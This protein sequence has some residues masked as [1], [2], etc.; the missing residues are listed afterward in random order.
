MAVSSFQ[1]RRGLGHS[2][3]VIFGA[4]FFSEKIYTI[5]N[6][7]LTGALLTLKFGQVYPIIFITTRNARW[8]TGQQRS[9]P[10]PVSVTGQPLDGAPA[11]CVVQVLHFCFHSS[12][13]ESLP[14][15]V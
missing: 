4:E 9:S 3:T 15:L 10:T 6:F 14:R 11:S 1:R 13:P 7:D 5:S 12:S 8:R 2:A